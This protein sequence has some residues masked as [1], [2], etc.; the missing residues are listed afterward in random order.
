[1]NKPKV[2]EKTVF[3]A[4]GEKHVLE[5]L[6]LMIGQQEDIKI[7]GYAQSAESLLVRVCKLSVNVIL[8]DWNLPGFNPQRLIPALRECCPGTKLVAY[9]IKPEHEKVAKDY[10]L[11]GFL[12]K[13]LPPETF[14][15]LLYAII[16]N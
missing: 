10:G 2:N 11:D 7:L 1:M 3:L 6:R 16:E 15:I 4:E 9:S 5:A 8:L 12:T 14:L 13:Q